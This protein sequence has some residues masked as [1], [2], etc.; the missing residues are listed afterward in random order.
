MFSGT[1]NTEEKQVWEDGI[2]GSGEDNTFSVVKL[3]L[4][5]EIECP[6]LEIQ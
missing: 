5:G 4:W 3:K 1:G 2:V 6:I